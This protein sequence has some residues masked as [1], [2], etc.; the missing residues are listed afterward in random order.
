MRKVVPEAVRSDSNVTLKTSSKIKQHK[1]NSSAGKFQV[2]PITKTDKP[3]ITTTIEMIEPKVIKSKKAVIKRLD[4]SK[5]SDVSKIFV[6]DESE[7]ISDESSNDDEKEAFPKNEAKRKDAFFLDKNG[8]A[9]VSSDEEQEEK[10]NNPVTFVGQKVFGNFK[11]F[12]RQNDDKFNGHTGG[13]R[14]TFTQNNNFGSRNLNNSS[15]Q[16]PFNG[17]RFYQSTSKPFPAFKKD[18]RGFSDGRGAPGQTPRPKEG[19]GGKWDC[20]IESQ[21]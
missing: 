3:C 19:G 17:G 8:N 14:K 4:F 20:L 2:S 16:K 5:A 6:E 18:F 21:Y 11:P 12:A 10:V 1:I 9:V 13:Q 7:A 15:H